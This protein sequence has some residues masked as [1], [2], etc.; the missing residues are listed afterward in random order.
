LAQC[1]KIVLLPGLDGSGQFFGNSLSYFEAYG[2]VLTICYPTSGSQSYA[3]LADFVALQ[4]PENDAF[5]VVAES[6]SGPIGIDLASRNISA[7]QGLLLSASF[8][9]DPFGLSSSALAN[10]VG[11]ARFLPIPPAA[12]LQWLLLG[13]DKSQLASALRTFLLAYNRQTLIKRGETALKADVVQKLKIIEMPVV[14]LVAR[15]DRLIARDFSIW[16]RFTN[17]EA[18]LIDGPHFLLQE[19]DEDQMRDALSRFF[20]RVSK[21]TGL[22]GLQ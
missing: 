13:D 8:F 20:A 19:G 14:S 11:L 22:K 17:V 5:V 15:Q 3:D 10:V 16:T 18:I 7:M 21:H 2:D 1:V 12:L 4:L 6:F 9:S